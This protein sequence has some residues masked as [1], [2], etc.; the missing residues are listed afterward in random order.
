V[1]YSILQI[2]QVPHPLTRALKAQPDVVTKPVISYSTFYLLHKILEPLMR[3]ELTTSSLPRKCSTPELQRL[4]FS[5]LKRTGG[6]WPNGQIFDDSR[7]EDEVRTRDLQLGRLSLY[8]LSYFRMLSACNAPVNANA[9]PKRLPPANKELPASRV[10]PDDLRAE[11]C[12]CLLTVGEDGFEP[13]N[14]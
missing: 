9:L 13:P 10:W 2:F 6:P 12:G 8:Q 11:T 4:L 7:A 14:S 3:I 5:I 1:F